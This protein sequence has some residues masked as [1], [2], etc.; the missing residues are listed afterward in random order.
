[1]INYFVVSPTFCKDLLSKFCFI[2][3]KQKEKFVENFSD[4]EVFCYVFSCYIFR[5]IGF[6]D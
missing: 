2:V 3:T 1:M 4:V 5:I 6:S